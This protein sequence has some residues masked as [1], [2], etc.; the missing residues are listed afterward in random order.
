MMKILFFTLWMGTLTAQA[1]DCLVH[2]PEKVFYHHGYTINFDFDSLLKSKGFFE[3]T[4]RS[5]PGKLI[6][7]GI[8]QE[9]R[10][11]RAVGRL[12]FFFKGES[13]KAEESVV[14]LTQLCA[15]ADYAK[16]FNKSYKKLSGIMPSCK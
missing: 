5:A 9:G 6:M 4:D 12:E 16:A 3:T 1:S 10:F 13:F 8:E 14:C 11:H 15:L 7:E 2:I